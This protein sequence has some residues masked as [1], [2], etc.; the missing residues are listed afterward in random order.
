MD[1]TSFVFTKNASCFGCNKCIFKCPTSA[2][3]AYFEADD[4][5]VFIK[6]GFCISCGECV[7]ICDHEARDYIDDTEFFFEDL[8]NNQNISVVVAPAAQFN[9]HEMGKIF[10]YLKSIGVNNI[11]DVSLGADICTWG[12]V[13]SIKEKKITNIIAQPCPV[14]VSY[15]EKYQPTLIEKLSPIQSPVICLAT[16]IKKYL[17]I[18]DKIAFLSP[19]VGKKRECTEENNHD[20]LTYNVTFEK[21]L[22]HINNA[23]IDIST[24]DS[25]GFDSIE[26]SLGFSFPRPGGLSENIKY[27]LREELWIKEI[28][29]IHNIK[30]YLSEYEKD[31]KENKPVPV[32]VDA[33]NCEQG[34]NLGTGTSKTARINEIDYITNERKSKLSKSNSKKL[35]S[36][37]DKTLKLEDFIRLYSDK[38]FDYKK[39]KDVDMES[40]YIS[41]GKYTQEDR[42][43]N[44]FCCGYGSCEAFVYDLA[45]GHNDKNNCRH[46]LLSKFKK[47][48]LFDELTGIRNRYSYS[49]AVEELLASHPGFVG[50]AYVDINGLKQAN[51]VLGHSFG[52]TLITTCASLLRKIFPDSVFRIG[53]DEFIVLD[54]SSSEKIFN[55]KIE[56]LSALL[57]KQ[58]NLVV[59]Y[60]I[61]ISLSSD[62][63]EEKM[64]EADQNM[65]AAKQ[66]YYAT[67]GRPDRRGKKRHH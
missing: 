39:E 22:N 12:H 21:F 28:E 42:S 10:S 54:N 62:D 26:G 34:C 2:N 47:L 32:I 5:K 27:H 16:Y 63:L 24:Y 13:K 37:F 3:E 7:S 48:S 59:S 29:G 41:L 44:C 43:I 35:L 51:D 18:T 36:H 65:Y 4:G 64:E 55:K 66:Q 61:A 19:C 57:E 53:G 50:I 9:I 14:V 58:K 46:F 31:L 25:I 38:S 11:Y 45:T 40:A 20:A 23:N 8:E 15:I 49:L 56:T 33:L 67:I 60:G 52:D 30:S 17:G 6:D 1:K